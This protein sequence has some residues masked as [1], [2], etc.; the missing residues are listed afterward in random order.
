MDLTASAAY[1]GPGWRPRAGSLAEEIADG[2]LWAPMSVRCDADRLRDVVLHCPPAERLTSGRPD[3]LQHLR[4]LRYARLRRDLDALAAAYGRL[5]ITV[6]EFAAP[7]PRPANPYCG[8]NAMYARDLLWMTGA[9]AVI[10][11]MA[12]AVRAGEEHQTLGLCARLGIPVARSVG[13]DG[14]FEGADALWL[15]PGLVAVGIGVR[16]DSS[17][18]RQVAEEAERQGASVLTLTVPRD[19]QHL[20]GVLQ[21]LDTDLLAA[22]TSRLESAEVRRL[23]ELGFDVV[24]VPEDEEVVR[25]FAFNFVTVAPRA[26]LMSEGSARTAALLGRHGVECVARVPVPELFGGAGGIGCATGILRRLA[27]D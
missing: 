23:R 13:A 20:L 18:A 11:R 12:S 16:T 3:Q 26:V 8:A 25:G 2:G 24:E 17:G 14:R 15:R 10:P 7:A 22:R 27:K 4:P 9:G 6:H 1:H 19:V 21:V 5:G